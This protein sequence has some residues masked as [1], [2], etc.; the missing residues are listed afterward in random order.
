MR[1]FLLLAVALAGS[2]EAGQVREYRYTHGLVAAQ[3]IH[4]IKPEYPLEAQ[5]K[6]LWGEGYYRLYVARDGSVTAV[7][8]IESTGHEVSMLPA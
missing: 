6:H 4:F 8:I 5:R 2:V 1:L 7:K 3:V